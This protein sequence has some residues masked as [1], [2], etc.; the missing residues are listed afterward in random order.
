[1][2]TLYGTPL[3]LYTGKA[4]S[5]LIKQ[6][7]AY[8]EITPTTTHFRDQVRPHAGGQTIPVLETAD[9]EVI[10]DSTA[11]IDFFEAQS[12]RTS[13]PMPDQVAEPLGPRR[14][15]VARLLDVMG[16]EGL[17]RPAMHYRWNYPQENAAFLAFH[18]QTLVPAGMDAVALAEKTMQRMQN[19]GRA[20][21][22]TKESFD[23]VEELYLEFL[24]LLNEHLRESP[25]LLG[26]QPTVADYGMIAPLYAHLGRD[27]KP[28]AIMQQRAVHVFRWVE[29]MNRPEPD[30][31]EFPALSAEALHA[32]QLADE[33]PE[34]LIN[35]LRHVARDFVPE[36]LAACQLINNWLDV[37]KPP[38]QLALER[39]VGMCEFAING[40]SIKA[41][42][43]PY[44]FYLLARAQQVYDESS[45]M[46]QAD[47]LALTDRCDLT[48]LLA[49]RLSRSIGRE[50]NQEVWLAANLA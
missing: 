34:T 50:N 28:L 18:F 10:R 1:M 24:F 17:M 20:F 8:R 16:A 19:A 3:S 42:A 40:Q 41:L 23:L 30:I 22:A 47:M 5:Y 15:F 45:E 38:A 48:P 46:A 26:Y 2:H 39:G 32:R 31:G 13:G 6:G 37:E 29:R 43:Q 21:G 35:L 36:T 11:I 44:R 25:Y 9:G 12:A 27:P 14:E 7:I 49:T 4:R 33:I